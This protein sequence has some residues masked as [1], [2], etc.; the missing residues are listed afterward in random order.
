MWR[1]LLW[2]R[3]NRGVGIVF[4]VSLVVK[5]MV[6]FFFSCYTR[7]RRRWKKRIVYRMLIRR[8]P[9]GP[10][11]GME[12]ASVMATFVANRWMMFSRLVVN[13]GYIRHSSASFRHLCCCASHPFP[14]TQH[15]CSSRG[16]QYQRNDFWHF[17]AR[18]MK[19]VD[20]YPKLWWYSNIYKL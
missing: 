12:P 13:T 16:Q 18:Y 6:Y 2:L 9:S 8:R 11:V 10:S 19:L 7:W 15:Q 20:W 4:I 14:F 1:C 17:S 3:W 5:K